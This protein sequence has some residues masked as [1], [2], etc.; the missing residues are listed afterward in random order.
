MALIECDVKESL[1]T[2]T[3]NRPEKRNALNAAMLVSLK[4]IFDQLE[5]DDSVRVVVLKG[6]GSIFCAGADIE[7]M[8]QQTKIE[9]LDNMLETL[10]NFPKALVAVVQGAAI[11]GGLGLVSCCDV[12]LARAET[13]FA[14][15][16][17]RLGILPAVILPYVKR[18]IG[19][20]QASRFMLTAERFE[21]DKAKEINLIH[22][23]LD[24]QEELEACLL[25]LLTELLKGGPEAQKSCKKLLRQLDSKDFAE[26]RKI[27][28]EAISHQRDQPEAQ[29]GLSAFLEKRKPSWFER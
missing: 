18:K 2:V 11:G 5:K 7:E 12:V 22:E 25:S 8:K 28:K 16:E 10:G 15:S 24:S 26:V 4:E 14:L 20:S 9:D 21:A 17:V 19:F 3:L 29:E 13:K 27:C 6:A 23:V 1:A